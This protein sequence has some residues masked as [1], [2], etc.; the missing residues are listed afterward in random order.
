V[1]PEVGGKKSVQLR[2]RL[3]LKEPECRQLEWVVE[4]SGRGSGRYHHIWI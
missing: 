3:T 1:T 2:D 4:Y